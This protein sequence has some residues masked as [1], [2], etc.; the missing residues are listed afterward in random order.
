[1]NPLNGSF[2]EG[3]SLKKLAIHYFYLVLEYTS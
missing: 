3:K 2:V 1:M